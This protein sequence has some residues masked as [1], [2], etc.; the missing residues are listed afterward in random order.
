MFVSAQAS[1]KYVT[2]YTCKGFDNIDRA[3]SERSVT[4]AIKKAIA[5]ERRTRELSSVEAARVAEYTAFYTAIQSGPPTTS[6][7]CLDFIIVLCIDID[8]HDFHCHC[9]YNSFP[10][11]I[12]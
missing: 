7:T 8:A 6:T 4:I 3:L 1:W 9:D 12:N 5:Q 2:A 10:T 11:S